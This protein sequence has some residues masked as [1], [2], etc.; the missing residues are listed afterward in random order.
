M[1]GVPGRCRGGIYRVGYTYPGTGEP[2][3]G[4]YT[5]PIGLREAKEAVIPLS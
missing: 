3:T 1:V 5:S 4:W 2:Y